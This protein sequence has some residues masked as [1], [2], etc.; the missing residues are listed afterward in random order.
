MIH[1]KGYQV[2]SQIHHSDSLPIG[3]IEN[4]NWKNELSF[5]GLKNLASEGSC[6]SPNPQAC[7]LV[8]PQR[9]LTCCLVGG[10]DGCEHEEKSHSVAPCPFMSPK[11]NRGAQNPWLQL[12]M[13]RSWTNEANC[14]LI[15]FP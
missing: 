3:S 6:T 12:N 1:R 2:I 9:T 10:M 5:T 4:L 7:M 15:R 13:T 8:P 14:G 11:K